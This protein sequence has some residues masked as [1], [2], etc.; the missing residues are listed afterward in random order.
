MNPTTFEYQINMRE[1]HTAVY[2]GFVNR[3]RTMLQIFLVV[4]AV[5]LLCT[6]GGFFGGIPV[7]RFP[8]YIFLG[9]LIWLLIL[10]AQVEHGVLKM[11]KLPENPLNRTLRL[12]FGRDQF[13]V[14]TP[15]NTDKAVHQIANLFFVFELSNLFM[16]YLDPANTILL[17]VRVMNGEQRA[18]LREK[19]RDSL[20]DRFQTRF[21]QM[22]AP[23]IRPL[24]GGR[25]FF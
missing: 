18:A 4:A 21:G 2:F 10:L 24:T 16:I 14:E 5:A 22:K 3:Y 15:S 1:Y 6:A 17:P 23:K 12:T 20:H 13:K 8:S 19:F 11:T 25:R 7:I 9:Y